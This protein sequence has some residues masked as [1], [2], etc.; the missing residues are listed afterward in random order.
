MDEAVR[1]FSELA[2]TQSV[3]LAAEVE[4]DLASSWRKMLITG[5]ACSI[6][7]FWLA[8]LI[9]KAIR[10]QVILMEEAKLAAELGRQST[11][12]LM[13]DLQKLQR[14]HELVLN[15]IGKGIHRLDGEG[16]IIFENPA[17]CRLLGWEASEL[18]GRQAHATVHHTRADGSPLRE[19]SA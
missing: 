5:V 8:W 19:R 6:L 16:Q 15:S 17:G 13:Q 3:S 2:Q 4:T 1:D 10:E 18:H 12:L 9:S 7:F 11:Q 14:D